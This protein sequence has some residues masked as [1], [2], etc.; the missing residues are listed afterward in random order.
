MMPSFV[1]DMIGMSVKLPFFRLDACVAWGGGQEAITLLL[2]HLL[3]IILSFNN[4]Y[5]L[6]SC[7]FYYG[8]YY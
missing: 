3:L 1:L 4:L 7:P 2:D 5:K 8:G 6:S